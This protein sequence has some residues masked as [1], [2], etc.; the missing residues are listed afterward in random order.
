MRIKQN[1]I[2][3][4]LNKLAQRILDI[5]LPF[6]VQ[7]YAGYGKDLWC[8]DY[9]HREMIR[10]LVDGKDKYL[11]ESPPEYLKNNNNY[12]SKQTYDGTVL[13][14][15]MLDTFKK[16]K[17]FSDTLMVC[18]C[19]W[20]IDIIL[21]A[22]VKEWKKIMG[23]DR[24]DPLIPEVNKFFHEELKLPVEL[25][26]ISSAGVEFSKINEP[27]IIAV[28]EPH[29]DVK[30]YEEIKNNP[31]ILFIVFGNIFDENLYNFK[32]THT[33]AEVNVELTFNPLQKYEKMPFL[34]EQ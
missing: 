19:G 15:K 25:Q 4:S 13:R 27:M 21:G 11:E 24:C 8:S 23:Y 34:L 30:Q 18:E 12:N 10:C 22:S 5:N 33:W 7:E 32:K 16:N 3:Y 2:K 9:W 1:E 29:F 6:G 31:N 26:C 28:N 17:D 14:L 20:G